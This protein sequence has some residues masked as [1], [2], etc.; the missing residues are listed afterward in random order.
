MLLPEGGSCGAAFQM[1]QPASCRDLGLL[2]ASST[3]QVT[4]YIFGSRRAD[5]G[6]GRRTQSWELGWGELPELC[7]QPYA[8]EELQ[9]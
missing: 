4:S 5:S 8:K 2:L 3:S 7:V 6:Q 9:L 1:V